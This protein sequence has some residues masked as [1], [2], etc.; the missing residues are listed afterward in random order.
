[1]LSKL[2]ESASTKHNL[3]PI[4]EKASCKLDLETKVSQPPEMKRRESSKALQADPSRTN[5]L[6][7][8]LFSPVEHKQGKATQESKLSM[9]VRIS[10]GMRHSE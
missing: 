7:R 6:A 5:T 1:M 10:K 2:G 8:V 4:K 9:A 3:A